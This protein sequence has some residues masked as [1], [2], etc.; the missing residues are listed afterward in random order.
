MATTYDR[1][2]GLVNKSGVTKDYS[3]IKDQSLLKYDEQ[4][5]QAITSSALS[6]TKPMVLPNAVITTDTNAASD[7]ITSSTEANK[8]AQA[9]TDAA[10]TAKDTALKDVTDTSLK[11]AGQSQRQDEI[12]VQEGG[13]IAKKDFDEYTSQIESEQT[14]VRRTTENLRKNNPEGLGIGALNNR[15]QEIER[16]SLSKQADLAI[17]QNSALRRYDTASA[18]ASRKVAAETDYLKA[19]LETK[20]L[21]YEDNKEA[22]TLAEQRQI[23]A[24]IKAEERKY[25]ETVEEKTKANAMIINALQSNA[26]KDL[27]TKAQ[28]ILSK[29]GTAAD[30][31]TALGQYSVSQADRLDLEIKKLQK[32]K[33]SNEINGGGS[34][35]APTVKTINGVDMQWDPKTQTWVPPS[36]TGGAATKEAVDKSLGQL[37]FLK[38]TATSITGDDEIY[39]AAGR[40]GGRKFIEGIVVGSTDYTKLESYANTLKVNVLALMTDPTIKKFF[41]PQMSNAD[42][43]L[44]TSAGTTI[45]PELQDGE[46]LK[47]EVVRLYDLFDRMETAVKKGTVEYQYVDTLDGI[48]LSGTALNPSSYANSLMKK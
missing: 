41:G 16:T 29:G 15:I 37:K 5:G 17:L 13:D 25:N 43:T 23:D 44:M 42:V 24:Q 9:K 46:T 47:D 3:G 26:P 1:R 10:K 19:E 32:T 33:L 8:V 7:L 45:N 31:A 35:E 40:S 11:L 21:I 30:V 20:K 22:F 27:V 48:D 4:S 14:S 36:S 34:T 2:T 6:P 18:I 38:D 28:G 12:F 39:G